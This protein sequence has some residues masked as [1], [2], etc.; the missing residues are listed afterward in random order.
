MHTDDNNAIR[1]LMKEMDPSEATE[2]EKHMREDEI[3]LLKLKA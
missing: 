1:Y 3:C 2:F